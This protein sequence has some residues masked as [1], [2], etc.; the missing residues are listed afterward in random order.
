MLGQLLVSG[1]T[2]GSIY[3]LA[4][5]GFA[6][7]YRATEVANFAQGELMM[8]SAMTALVL[9]RDVELPYL[10]VVAL[11]VVTTMIVAFLVERIAFRPLLGAPHITVLLSTVAVG[12]IIRSGVRAF[13]G[14][15]FGVFPPVVSQEPMEIIEG[16]RFTAVN[17]LVLG[18]A[19]LT[20]LVFAA[21]FA[22]TRMG[23]AMRATAQNLRAA[24]IVG[25][26]VPKTFSQTWVIAG[27]LAAVAGLLLA[28]L[29]IVTPDMGVIANKGFVAAII[30]GFASLPGAIVGGLLLGVTENLIGV[31]ISSAFKD[32]I[33]FGLLIL[34]LLV[35][36]SGLF[37]KATVTRV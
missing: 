7:I 21:V 23:W 19:G 36:P 29:V 32:V 28:P 26:N 4:A 13:H 35:R 20:L 30:G 16:I 5:L 12:Q 24:A 34:F 22:F 1:L 10:A 31:Y 25:I 27:G 8:L 33:V 37:G 18:M 9:Y 11:A 15:D 17:L 3:A 2:L 14:D 6:V